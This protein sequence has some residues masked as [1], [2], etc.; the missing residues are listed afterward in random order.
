MI[1][2]FLHINRNCTNKKTQDINADIIII[3]YSL[4]ARRVPQR[5]PCFAIGQENIIIHVPLQ[6]KLVSP[7]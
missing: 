2:I 3:L 7:Q 4:Y 6:F 5:F 1:N